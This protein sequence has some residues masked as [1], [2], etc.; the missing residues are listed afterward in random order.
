MELLYNDFNI[1][2]FFD[3]TNKK[4]IFF[5]GNRKIILDNKG[6]ILHNLKKEGLK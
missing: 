2:L 4:Y 5:I 6:K 3:T 1:E